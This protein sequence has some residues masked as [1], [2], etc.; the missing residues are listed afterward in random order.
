MDLTRRETLKGLVASG[1]VIPGQASSATSA[2]ARPLSLTLDNGLRAHIVEN[3]SRYIAGA[4]L[5]R[6][7][8]IRAADGLAHILEHTSFAGAAG[9]FAAHQIKQMHQDYIQD[10]NASTEPGMIQWQVSFLPKYLEQVLGLLAIVSLDQKFDVQTVNQEARVVLQELYLHRYHTRFGR[11]RLLGTAL[12]GPHHPYGIET[13][14]SEMAKARTR[15]DR[16]A[17][18]LRAYAQTIRL[19]ANMDLF[20]AGGLD[21]SIVA[22][23]V[24]KHF[25]AFPFAQGPMLALPQAPVTRA[26]RTFTLS[27]PE[28]RRPLSKMKIAWNTG[29]GIM[30]SD[31]KV[32]LALS[33]YLNA[34]LFRQLRERHGDAYA[35]SASYDPDECS[36]IF[37][38]DIPGTEAPNRIERKVFDGIAGLKANIGV[39][40]LGRFRDR[41]ELRRRQSAENNE[42]IVER[43]VQ[44]AVEGA[45]LHDF[46]LD[47]ITRD[48]VLAAAAR[49]LP[50]YKGAYVRLSLIGR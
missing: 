14:E 42:A 5:L 15:P 36:G 39:G 44:R 35:P 26:Y 37:E 17:A 29:I 50:T 19:P 24:R 25:G 23:I 27:S 46:D 1:A 41:L 43:L 31:A 33:E 8:E 47:T 9:A 12:F 45:S 4:L 16:L 3:G 11:R 21:A 20:L 10:A 38:I 2:N 40:E 7:N 13:T 28:L 6:S 30:H 32:V 48:S 34:M 22:S 18:E 49:Y